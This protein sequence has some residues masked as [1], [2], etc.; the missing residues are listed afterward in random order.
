MPTSPRIIA[1]GTGRG[2]GNTII[3]LVIVFLILFMVILVP[4]CC[5]YRRWDRRSNERVRATTRDF[6]AS[7]EFDQ[8]NND[9]PPE[10]LVILAMVDLKPPPYKLQPDS[11]VPPS[12]YETVAKSCYG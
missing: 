8:T 4:V 3:P 5:Y 11:S 10:I 7:T 6:V 1:C 9:W 2:P 12:P